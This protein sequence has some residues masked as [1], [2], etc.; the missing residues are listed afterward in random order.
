ML[1]LYPLFPKINSKFLKKRT[2]HTGLVKNDKTGYFNKS[3]SVIRLGKKQ[4]A[5][6]E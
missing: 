6:D 2:G 4:E 1:I 5:R 3:S